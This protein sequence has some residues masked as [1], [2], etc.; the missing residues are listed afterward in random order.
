MISK[1]LNYSKEIKW[2]HFEIIFQG[3]TEPPIYEEKLLDYGTTKTI[4]NTTNI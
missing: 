2:M 3:T 4:R 1:S